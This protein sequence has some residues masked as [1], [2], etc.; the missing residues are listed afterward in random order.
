[1]KFDFKARY[2]AP[3]SAVIKMFCDKDFHSRKLEAL[4]LPKYQVL[5]H[6]FDGKEFRIRMERHVPMQ[7]PGLIKKLIPAETRVINDER[8]DVAKRTGKVKVE[9]QGVPVEMTCT[10]AMADEGGGCV[11]T[12]RWEVT[13]RVPL[14]GGTLEKFVVG[15]MEKKMA[16]ETSVGVTLVNAYR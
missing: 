6:K 2:P 9:P 12:Y 14:L 1:M 15:D 13:A 5:E 11:V 10:A 8:W 7:V 3:A 16:E 4:G